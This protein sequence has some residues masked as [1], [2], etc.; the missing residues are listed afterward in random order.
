[1]PRWL[2]PP[3]GADPD[4][5]KAGRH[6][7]Q[8]ITRHR[9]QSQAEKAVRAVALQV[10][11]DAGKTHTQ[12]RSQRVAEQGPAGQHCYRDPGIAPDDT[13]TA[14]TRAA[15]NTPPREQ[16]GIAPGRGAR[17]QSFK[18]SRIRMRPR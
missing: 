7:E 4:R 9:D 5:R 17:R 15:S 11:F 6:V 8:E 14:A 2:P 16:A 13:G 18:Y 10:L 1:M 12:T 3:V